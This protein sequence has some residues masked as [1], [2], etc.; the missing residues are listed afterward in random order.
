MIVNQRDE[1]TSAFDVEFTGLPP[2]IT[3][4]DTETVQMLS[5]PESQEPFTGFSFYP[6][7]E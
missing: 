7:F 5:K 1:D 2:A 4:V 6:E 3:P